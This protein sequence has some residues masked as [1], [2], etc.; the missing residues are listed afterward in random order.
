MSEMPTETMWT[1]NLTGEEI[2]FEYGMMTG[3]YTASHITMLLVAGM[4]AEEGVEVEPVDPARPFQAY[5][6]PQS[7]RDSV[8][9]KYI[10]PE[11]LYPEH[12][13]DT[14]AFA[15]ETK[16]DGTAYAAQHPSPTTPGFDESIHRP[17]TAAEKYILILA[18][19]MGGQYYSLENAPGQTGY[20]GE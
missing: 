18:A 5:M 8:L 14:I 10:Q 20:E 11:Q 6:V 17:L 15:G 16:M 19:D 12:D 2:T 3:N 4:M 7:A 9:I 13:P 1:F